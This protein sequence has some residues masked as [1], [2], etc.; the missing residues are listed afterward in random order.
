MRETILTIKT[1]LTTGSFAYDKPVPS[2][3][4]YEAVLDGGVSGVAEFQTWLKQRLP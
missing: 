3:L 4:V 2:F 1:E